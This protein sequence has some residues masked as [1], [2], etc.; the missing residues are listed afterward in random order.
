MKKWR[1]NF[2]VLSLFTLLAFVL[3]ACGKPFLSTLKPAGEVAEEQYSLM[4]L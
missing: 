3:S 2:R 4:L 1:L